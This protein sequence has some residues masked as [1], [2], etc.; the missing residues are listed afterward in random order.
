MCKPW[1]AFTTR[2]FPFDLPKDEAQA[3]IVVNRTHALKKLVLGLLLFTAVEECS[4]AQTPP[5]TNAPAFKQVKLFDLKKDGAYVFTFC[6]AS[7]DLFVSFNE[8]TSQVVYRW[9]A[10]TGRKLDSYTFPKKYRCDQAV[11]SPDGK[12]LVLVAYDMLHDA[13]HKADTVQ[14]IDVQSGKLVK[15]LTYD[16]TPAR[17]QFSRDGKFIIT[18]K[19]TYDP[20]GELVYDIQGNR[21]NLVDFEAFNPIE[22]SNVWEIPNSKGGPP[23]G[24]FFRDLEGKEHRLLDTQ[25][26]DYAVS[27]D[28]HHVACAT[29]GGRLM[30]W[31]TV[32]SKLVFES[33]I[34]NGPFHISYDSNKARFLFADG[35]T[36]KMTWL[37]AIQI[38]TTK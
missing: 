8:E 24:L 3:R 29:F 15:E 16:G 18:R 33:Q 6:P 7:R 5:E 34:G 35:D 13:L 21:V 17:V 10:D 28:Q 2:P 36:D 20:G 19:Y 26:Y 14:L 22:K 4:F 32:D 25:P 31:Q 27:T 11:F 38:E 30:I 37:Q 1:N 9:N 12:M 23:S